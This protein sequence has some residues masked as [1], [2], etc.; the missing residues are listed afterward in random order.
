M[1]TPTRYALQHKEADMSARMREKG[2]KRTE[3]GVYCEACGNDL[4]VDGSAEIIEQWDGAKEYGYNFKCTK[5]GAILSQVC[6]RS[7]AGAMWWADASEPE[8]EQGVTP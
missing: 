1:Q 7:Q 2:V 8:E 6:E 4:S 3:T 5:C